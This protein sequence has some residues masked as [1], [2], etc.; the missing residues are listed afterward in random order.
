M[1]INEHFESMNECEKLNLYITQTAP[2]I[3]NDVYSVQSWSD[4]STV[5][6]MDC[7]LNQSNQKKNHNKD[8][9]GVYIHPLPTLVYN[10]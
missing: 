3:T 1:V 2:L 5:E 9:N 8:N 6:L 7:S 4:E 10:M